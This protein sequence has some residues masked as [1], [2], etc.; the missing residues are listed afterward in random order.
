MLDYCGD[1]CR[2]HDRDRFIISLRAEA[3]KRPALWA[4][5]ALN[6]EIART[7]EVVTEPIL[8]RIRLQWWREA[9]D[10]ALQPE[11]PI[12]RH[13]ILRYLA[14]HKQAYGLRQ[15]LFHDL[16]DA[17][18]A[19][20]AAGKVTGL[21]ALEDYAVATN[22]PLLQLGMAICGEANKPEVV[23]AVAGAYGLV[24]LLRAHLRHTVQGSYVDDSAAV[25]QRAQFMLEEAGR[26]RGLL[27]TH[28]AVAALYLKRLARH[29]AEPPPF[30]LLRLMWGR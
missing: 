18:E 22:L 15:E 23:R 28:K 3:G 24:G 1:I 14:P 26:V 20:M 10:E 12:Y 16:I 6:Y 9:V 8:G 21:A 27:G 5:Y 19:D 29:G 25:A 17:R 7:R 2:L 30:Q 13:E 11:A 4:L